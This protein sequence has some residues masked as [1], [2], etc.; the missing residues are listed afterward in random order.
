MEAENKNLLLMDW[1]LL[2]GR[3]VRQQPPPWGPEILVVQREM[4]QNIWERESGVLVVFLG[5]FLGDTQ[6]PWGCFP[7]VNT[8][9]NPIPAGGCYGDEQS[10]N[11]GV[12]WVGRAPKTAQS[13]PPAI[14]PPDQGAQMMLRKPWESST[15]QPIMLHLAF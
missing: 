3:L 14:L 13:Q 7:A 1:S 11:P 10:E 6:R 2:Q 4:V 15:E 5:L 9:G 12:F 8:R